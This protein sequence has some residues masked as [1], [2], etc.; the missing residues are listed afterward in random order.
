VGLTGAWLPWF[1]AV[2]ALVLFVGVVLGR[3]RPRVPRLAL[4]F[5]TLHVLGL[6]VVVLML[7]GVLLNDQYLFYVSW[8]DLLG[9]ETGSFHVVARGNDREGARIRLDP[10][11]TTTRG[12]LPP[13]PNPGSQ[14]QIYHVTGART[15]LSGEVAVWLPKGYDPASER[16]YPVIESLAGYPGSALSSFHG[17]DL[18]GTY[19][20]LIDE[21]VIRPPIIVMPQINTPNSL[22]TECVNA[23]EGAG[24]Q[25]ETW[26]ASDVPQWVAAHFRIDAHRTSW[27]VQGFSYG[28]WCSA[29]LAMHHPDVFG[30]AMVLMGYFTPEFTNYVPFGPHSVAAEDYDLPL[31]A[32]EHP[33]AVSMWVMV[34]KTDRT[35]YPY[36]TEFLRKVHPPMDV[37]AQV[38]ATGGHR[39]QAIPPV[40]R[41]MLRWLARTLPGFRYRSA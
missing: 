37:T 27:A 14:E 18:R 1:L 22:D 8:S 3:P 13:L 34:S 12:N 23:P 30:G 11:L 41:D 40:E 15:G 25:T 16:T 2:V 36:V 28:G 5:R 33:P 17:F 6:N 9:S 10:V 4:G 35:S 38:Q 29:M 24:P 26:L 31:M 39:V 19:Q 7:A 21:H 20:R 32:L